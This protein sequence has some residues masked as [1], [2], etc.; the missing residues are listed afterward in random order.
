MWRSR[1]PYDEEGMQRGDE[2]GERRKEVGKPM[3]EGMNEDGR[4]EN[5]STDGRREM[6]TGDGR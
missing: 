5:R 4:R 2:G 3:D 6:K 1:K